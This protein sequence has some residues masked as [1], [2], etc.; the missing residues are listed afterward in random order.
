MVNLIDSGIGAF[1]STGER[2]SSGLHNATV[3]NAL[4]GAI[5][6][7]I[8]A[9]PATFN[10]VDNLLKVKDKNILLLIHSVVFAVIM[11][12]GSLLIFKPVLDMLL[13]EGIST[14]PTKKTKK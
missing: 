3:Q 6:F 5:T 11:Y 4:F 8:V 13:R 2:I 9:H 7:I 1:K 10:F 12:F 14:P